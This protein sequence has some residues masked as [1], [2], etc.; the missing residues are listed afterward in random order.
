MALAGMPGGGGGAGRGRGGA[1]PGMDNLM[2][3][4]MQDPELME[5]MQDPEI[6]ACL[7][8]PS[9]AMGNPKAMKV[10]HSQG[11]CLL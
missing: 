5:A 1:P 11:C 8:D 6:M 2:N 10:Q 4:L 3:V 9:K 7:Q